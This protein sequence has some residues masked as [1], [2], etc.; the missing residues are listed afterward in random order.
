MEKNALSN[1][2][3]YKH[4]PSETTPGIWQTFVGSIACVQ[5]IM[6]HAQRWP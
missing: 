1:P 6:G 2:V 5:H 3:P 4:T